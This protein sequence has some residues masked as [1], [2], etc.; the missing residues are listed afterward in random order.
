MRLS[1]FAGERFI[2]GRPFGTEICNNAISLTP[3]IHYPRIAPRI[4]REISP[5][6]LRHTLECAAC[7]PE[8]PKTLLSAMYRDSRLQWAWSLQ[9]SADLL[10]YLV[11][12]GII[13]LNSAHRDSAFA[14]AVPEGSVPAAEHCCGHDAPRIFGDCD[15]PRKVVAP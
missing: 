5:F 11:F 1:A 9:F 6:S 3:K 4:R 12:R 7:E 10:W 13:L 2:F 15:P 14:A 8:R